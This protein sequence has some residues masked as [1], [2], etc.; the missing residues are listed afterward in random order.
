MDFEV[1]THT[2]IHASGRSRACFIFAEMETISENAAT[3][4]SHSV[5]SVYLKKGKC[6]IF[7]L[8]IVYV[9]REL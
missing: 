9:S 2:H 3:A 6:F 1:R 8:C 7:I 4:V 5:S